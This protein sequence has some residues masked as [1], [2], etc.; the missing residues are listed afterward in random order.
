MR[1]RLA[2]SLLSIYLIAISGMAISAHFC[3]GR[4]DVVKLTIGLPRSSYTIPQIQEACCQDF[5]KYIKLQDAH[6]GSIFVYWPID[7]FLPQLPLLHF[8]TASF[9]SRKLIPTQ[10]VSL[11]NSPPLFVLHQIWLI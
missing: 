8:S 5:T 10:E 3:C 11:S 6:Q 4:L 7:V 2:I 9:F 1:R